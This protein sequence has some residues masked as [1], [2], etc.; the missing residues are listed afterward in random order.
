MCLQ[1]YQRDD[2]SQLHLEHIK[3]SN[4]V[5]KLKQ[6]IKELDDLKAKVNPED[7][8]YFNE[9][10]KP[11]R[12]RILKHVD[13]LISDGNL[14]LADPSPEYSEEQ[15]LSTK[16][17]L[18]NDTMNLAA[19]VEEKKRVLSSWQNLKREIAELNDSVFRLSH[20]VWVSLQL[21]QQSPSES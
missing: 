13:D 16:L 10:A 1:C 11:L 8:N 2:F 18:K 19:E 20:L 5:K 12:E 21:G 17:E 14:F 7:A 15:F 4:I 9:R 3:A 6:I